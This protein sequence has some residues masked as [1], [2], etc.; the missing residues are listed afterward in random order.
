MYCE[1]IIEKGNN[2]V[3]YTTNTAPRNRYNWNP[4]IYNLTPTFSNQDFNSLSPFKDTKPCILHKIVF[5]IDWFNI[6]TINIPR[7][8]KL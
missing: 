7:Q 3:K 1:S 4:L 6:I 5:G 8:N 2:L